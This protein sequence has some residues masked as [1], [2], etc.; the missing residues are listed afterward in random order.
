MLNKENPLGLCKAL[1]RFIFRALLHELTGKLLYINLFMF[2]VKLIGLK[3]VL[4]KNML[5]KATGKNKSR[6][7]CV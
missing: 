4:Y 3:H 5:F 7:R 1:F 2:Y 6:L